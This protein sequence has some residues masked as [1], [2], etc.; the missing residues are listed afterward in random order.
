MRQLGQR[1]NN[2]SLAARTESANPTRWTSRSPAASL[3]LAFPPRDVDG[4][5]SDRGELLDGVA[6]RL[7]P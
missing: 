3:E 4:T 1:T 2:V 5:L 7:G 6:E